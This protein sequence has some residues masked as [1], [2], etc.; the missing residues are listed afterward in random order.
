MPSGVPGSVSRSRIITRAMDS[1][2]SLLTRPL[3]E[4]RDA[5]RAISVARSARRNDTR[6]MRGI[7]KAARDVAGRRRRIA[8]RRRRSAGRWRDVATAWGGL[9][10]SLCR[11]AEKLRRAQR[12]RAGH[13]LAKGAIPLRGT[14]VSLTVSRVCERF[15]SDPPPLPEFLPPAQTRQLEHHV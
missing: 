9:H 5:T 1:K 8:T 10:G 4:V 15:R 13:A 12:G 7:T 11:G 2:S 3:C 14:L 6:R